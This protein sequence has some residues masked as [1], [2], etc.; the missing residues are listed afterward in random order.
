M[1]LK[2]VRSKTVGSGGKGGECSEKKEE[3]QSSE[4]EGISAWYEECPA[5]NSGRKDEGKKTERRTKPKNQCQTSLGQRHL[6]RAWVYFI[7]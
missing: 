3:E 5:E 4:A 2:E 1:R 6:N 7:A